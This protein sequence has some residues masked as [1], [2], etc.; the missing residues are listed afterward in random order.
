VLSF[1]SAIAR[2]DTKTSNTFARFSLDFVQEKL[3]PADLTEQYFQKESVIIVYD[4]LFLKYDHQ[5]HF[6]GPGSG[7]SVAADA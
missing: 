4:I 5:D 1:S 7:I 3:E 6:Q 2:K